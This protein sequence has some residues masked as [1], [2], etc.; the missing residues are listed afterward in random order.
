MSPHFYINSLVLLPTQKWWV[1]KTKKCRPHSTYPVPTIRCTGRYYVLLIPLF[2]GV[3]LIFEL[4]QWIYFWE[5]CSHN[6]CLWS[7]VRGYSY[8]FQTCHKKGDVAVACILQSQTC[9]F[10]QASCLWRWVSTLRRQDGEYE[11]PHTQSTAL[12]T[13]KDPSSQTM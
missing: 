12:I 3:F 2:V 6:L 9:M 10:A 11:S 8:K 7:Y 1:G 5:N 4:E 13:Y